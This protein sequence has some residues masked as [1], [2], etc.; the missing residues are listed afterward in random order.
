MILQCQ[1]ARNEMM[2]KDSNETEQMKH[3]KLRLHLTSV[4]SLGSLHFDFHDV[5]VFKFWRAVWPQIFGR[6]YARK[7]RIE[8]PAV[9]S[10]Q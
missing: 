10:L 8:N 4:H 3:S 9:H 5:C 7:P 2:Q 6:I 1:F